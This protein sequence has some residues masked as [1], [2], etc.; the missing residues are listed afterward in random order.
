MHACRHTAC[1]VRLPLGLATHHSPTTSPTHSCVPVWSTFALIWFDDTSCSLMTNVSYHWS[2]VLYGSCWLWS[3]S[4]GPCYLARCLWLDTEPLRGN[5]PRFKLW[6]SL[7]WNFTWFP[8]S[9]LDLTA[10]WISLASGKAGR[11]GPWWPQFRALTLRF[12]NCVQICLKYLKRALSESHWKGFP[13]PA[14]ENWQ[15]FLSKYQKISCCPVAD[16][17]DQGQ[18]GCN[19][20]GHLCRW[21]EDGETELSEISLQLR[22]FLRSLKLFAGGGGFQE[23]VKRTWDHIIAFIYI[24]NPASAAPKLAAVLSIKHFISPQPLW[25]RSHPHTGCLAANPSI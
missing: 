24:P 15:N 1:A 8:A 13:W 16:S 4:W 20:A 25:Q 10:L 17:E 7:F 12:P 9:C 3:T 5:C 23:S 14:K 21:V 22:K 18:S 11:Q 2:E 19:R 6:L